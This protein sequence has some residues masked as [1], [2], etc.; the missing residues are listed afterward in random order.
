MWVKDSKPVSLR[1][2]IA[3]H[4]P[5]VGITLLRYV[6]FLYFP[7]QSPTGALITPTPSSL[8]LGPL[9]PERLHMVQSVHVPSISVSV[10]GCRCVL[11]Q[12]STWQSH[13]QLLLLLRGPEVVPY[14]P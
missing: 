12:R 3:L 13:T 6:F 14:L 4:D 7:S 10:K 5:Q 1:I 11:C 8:H 2:K 9:P